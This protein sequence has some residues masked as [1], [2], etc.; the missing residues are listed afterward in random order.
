MPC[1]A[2]SA[3]GTASLRGWTVLEGYCV[4]IVV[5]VAREDA[6][7]VSQFVQDGS[8]EVIATVGSRTLGGF[9]GG[10]SKR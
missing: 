9:E 7:Q 2:R 3:S 8:E 10:V 5:G 6:C 1:E 4:L